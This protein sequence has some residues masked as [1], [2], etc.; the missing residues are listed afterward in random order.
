MKAIPAGRRAVVMGLAACLVAGCQVV[1]RSAEPAQRPPPPPPQQ[2]VPQAET[3]PE[4]ETRHRVALLVPMS[5]DDGAVGQS[6]A[7]ATT[8]ALLDT[9]AENLRITAYDTAGGASAAARRAVTDGNTLI[10]GP[11]KRENAGA[12]RAEA[13]A[14]NVPVISFSN[15]ADIAGSGV[16][17]LGH[18]PE[19]SI[20][21]SMEYLARAGV[22]E[23]SAIAPQGDYGDRA[24]EAL[25]RSAAAEEVGVGTVQ[26]YARS[27]TSVIS[28]AQRLSA[29]GEPQAVLL[30]DSPG[31]AARAARVLREDGQVQLV[32]TE[33]WSGEGELARL[34]ALSGAI[35]SAVSD[36]N[37][38]Q[39]A[40]SYRARFG[41]APYRISTL[42]YDGVLLALNIAGNWRV[43]TPFPAS[44]LLVDE[45]F[46]GLDGPFRFDSEGKIERAME[47]RRIEDG[48]VVVVSPAPSSF[49]D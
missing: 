44:R 37:F 12:V 22:Q 25:R 4:D 16:F 27:N 41:N 49:D 38:R 21:R 10:L 1:P 47:V 19:Q 46:L 6:L 7:N 14:G 26:R 34:P 33:L 5:G 32:G 40:D 18:L 23:I 20:A 42:G 35:F 45:G 29:E 36:D 2:P 11:L 8:M 43:G 3:L 13:R 48:R 31:L 9:G 17:V 39:F 28:A 15:D 30:A 24:V